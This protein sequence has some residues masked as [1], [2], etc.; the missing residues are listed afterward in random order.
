MRQLSDDFDRFLGGFFGP[1]LFRSPGETAYFPELEVQHKGNTLVIQA[2][3]PGLKKEDLTI[4]V[5]DNGLI[6]SGERRSESESTEGGYFRTERSY[7][8]FRRTVPLPKG[9]KPDTASATFEDGVLKIEMEAPVDEQAQG[10]R[11]EVREGRAH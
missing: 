9:A 11:I 4:E 2:D 10:R 5:R 1:G 6:I 8:S 3:V 7:G